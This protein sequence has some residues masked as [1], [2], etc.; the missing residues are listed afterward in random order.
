M[1]A[2][3]DTPPAAGLKSISIRNF[4]GIESLDLSFTNPRGELN[5]VTV[6]GGPNGC[7][8]TSVLEACL[9]VLGHGAKLT[10]RSQG[11]A[12]AFTLS[13]NGTGSFL[14]RGIRSSD[15]LPSQLFPVARTEKDW[16][17]SRG[18]DAEPVA[19]VAFYPSERVQRLPGSVSPLAAHRGTAADE[20]LLS[21]KRSLVNFTFGALFQAWNRKSY[22]SGFRPSSELSGSNPVRAINRAWQEFYPGQ[23]VAVEP[24]D[25]APRAAP[26]KMGGAD[27]F[28]TGEAVEGR[29]AVDRL[30]SG[31]LELLVL[32]GSL[33]LWEGESPVCIID[34]PELHLDPSWHRRV[35]RLFRTLKPRAQVIA[36]THSPEVF[37]SVRSWEQ[38]YLLPPGDPREKLWARK[39]DAAPVL[40]PAAA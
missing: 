5:G 1:P 3:P 6:L 19:E 35:L 39:S 31:Q 12:D 40:R 16:K 13:R 11:D 38:K 25:D 2:P 23:Q 24:V 15:A 10:R 14:V 18:E 29:L 22:S 37:D 36:A 33:V 30:S 27:L 17:K 21:I 4:R 34:E 20:K 7:G 28:I 8:K 26:P 9:I 32:I